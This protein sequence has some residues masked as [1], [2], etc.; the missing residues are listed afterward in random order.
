MMRKYKCTQCNKQGVKLW[1]EFGNFTN[2]YCWEC[3][4]SNASITTDY[5]YNDEY[6]PAFPVNLCT[7]KWTFEGFVTLYDATED[8]RN[9]WNTLS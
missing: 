7:T 2:L 5:K 4:P 6:L 8:V 1:R 3:L 9:V